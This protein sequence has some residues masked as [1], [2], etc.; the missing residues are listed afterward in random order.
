MGFK[1]GMHRLPTTDTHA[2][3]AQ[4]I[5]FLANRDTIEIST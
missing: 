3:I 1:V 4:A 5:E 2:G